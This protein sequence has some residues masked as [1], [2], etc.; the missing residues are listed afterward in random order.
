MLKT[1]LQCCIVIDMKIKLT[2]VVVVE[3]KQDNDRFLMELFIDG[4]IYLLK[5]SLA[6]FLIILSAI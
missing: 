2:V 3:L 1:L 4:I 5:S 6:N